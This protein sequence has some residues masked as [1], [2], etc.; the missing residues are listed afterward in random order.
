MEKKFWMVWNG[1]A[2]NNPSTMRHETKEAAIQEAARLSRN[3]T[4]PFYVLEAVATVQAK[5]EYDVQAI[6]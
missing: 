4:G 1:R 6:C 5:F 3:A 2:N